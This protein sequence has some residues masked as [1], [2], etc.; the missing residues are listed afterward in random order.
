MKKSNY[1]ISKTSQNKGF[2]GGASRKESACLCRSLR[3]AVSVP[4]SGKYPGGEHDNTFQYSCL[5]N[6]MDRG[7]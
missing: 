6:P 1:K 4:G 7:A 2:P 5:E 3:D